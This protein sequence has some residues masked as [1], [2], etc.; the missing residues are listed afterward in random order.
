[1]AGAEFKITDAIDEGIFRKLKQIGEEAEKVT[2]VYSELAKQL[3]TQTNFNPT[4]FEDLRKKA[5]AGNE[6]LRKLA[7]T[8]EEL[9]RLQKE[10]K[11][12]YSEMSKEL[13]KQVKIATAKAKQEAAEIAR[14]RQR[15][16]LENDKQKAAKRT[17][18][19]EKEISVALNTQ[20]KS[21]AEA[22]KQNSILRQAVR[23]VD[24]T[25]DDAI[26]TINK[27]NAKI[28]ENDA[29]MDKFA[30]GMT[31]RKRNIGNY[32]SAFDGLGVSV[33][34]V[35][36][37]LPALSMGLNTF[38]LAISNNIPM[39]VDEL[40]KAREANAKLRKEG[41]STIPVWKQVAS[42]IFSWQTALM[43]GVTLLSA[44]G[45]DIVEWAGNLFKGKEAAK[46]YKDSLAD[47]NEALRENMGDYGE[48]ITKL[49][50][51]QDAWSS[52]GSNLEQQKT[53][54]RENS[55]F[56]DE[57]G[58][59]VKDVNDAEKLFVEKTP[60]L[61]EALSLKAKATAA[62][63]LAVEEETK[64]MKKFME[65]E[66]AM[67]TTNAWDYWNAGIDVITNLDAALQGVNMWNPEKYAKG[68]AGGLLLEADAAETVASS[69]R[70]LFSDLSDKSKE[71]LSGAGFDLTTKID[72]E[73]ENAIKAYEDYI[74]DIKEQSRQLDIDLIEDSHE[75][76][77][78]SIKKEYQ[79]RRDAIKGNTEAEIKLREQLFKMEAKALDEEQER[80]DME[81]RAKLTA[82][83]EEELKGV[84][85]AAQLQIAALKNSLK[86]QENELSKGNKG[87]EAD[88]K[89]HQAEML[90]LTYEYNK[91]ILLAQLEAAEKELEI[92]E[93]S[94]AVPEAKME[95]MKEKVRGLKAEI[96]GLSI[97]WDNDENER[98]QKDK[99]A[100]IDELAKA[101][102]RVTD[103]SRE[104]I[105][106][107]ADMF[108]VAND[109]S[110][111]IAKGFDE[112]WESLDDDDRFAYIANKFAQ[113][114]A[115]I[116]Q[117]MSDVYARRIEDIEEEQDKLDEAERKEL[118]RIER[119]EDVGAIS[120]E[121]SEAR[122][123]AAEDR[124]AKKNEELEKK[125]A[126]LQ[127]KQAKWEKANSIAQAAIATALA[128]IK[129]MPNFVLAAV[130]AALGAAQIGM[131][132]A[133]P[134]PKYK[135]GTNYHKGGLAVVGD[136]GVAETILTNNGAFITPSVPTIVDLPR[137]AKVL[138]Y[139][140][141]VDMEKIKAKAS[142]LNALVA[143]RTEN[144]LPPIN[145]ETDN[146]GVEKRIEKLEESQR[147]GFKELSKAI[148]N[149]DFKRFAASI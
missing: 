24:I 31:K 28:E 91:Q 7:E 25:L 47:I 114:A 89:K 140:I 138:P 50:T 26:E 120:K 117:V 149:Q 60:V 13:E 131:I 135:N 51:L 59:S 33:Q 27:Y 2:K 134:L 49:K 54:I 124:T 43:V 116:T 145:I 84:N 6:A 144:A 16:K 35:A 63:D 85:E 148:K 93:A 119:L 142:D 143:Y 121:E 136:G 108:S 101:L 125:K 41:Q 36:R 52:L 34:Q 83:T 69:Y 29:L 128:V 129:C 104:V 141:D 106:G 80:Y 18:V 72:K 19:T 94:M 61:I 22:A 56:F 17:A 10:Q 78:A 9:R 98:Q 107:F 105:G 39:L 12:A 75:R 118:D 15:I 38:V 102:N 100:Q 110:L 55:D 147:R 40:N 32:A 76:N 139:S 130:V 73:T 3:A 96:E 8:E 92:A 20:A 99:E 65:A 97:K 146:R 11:K 137:G 70:K 37:E 133:T 115:G 64:A 42:S 62:Y 57:L 23:K 77:I 95:E 71:L 103:A 132:M 123:R 67:A 86:E 21:L 30:D 5:E 79:D 87:T 127:M 111:D 90:K 4:G 53:F 44:Y 48:T 112:M 66:K 122:K 109:V 74:N 68:R 14:E 113:L 46:S 58:I 126:A 88:K 45:K 82:Q 1:M 81:R